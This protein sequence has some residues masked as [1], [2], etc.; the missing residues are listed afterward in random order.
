MNTLL[1][2]SYS[3]NSPAGYIHIITEADFIVSIF[4]TN[5]SNPVN[6]SIENKLLIESVNQ[7]KAYFSGRLHVFDLPL[8][9]KGT[10]FQKEVWDILKT[11]PFGETRTYS[12]IAELAGGPQYTRAVGNANGNNPIA[13]IIPCHR[14]IGA[15]GS[16][17]GYAGGIKRKKWLLD[18]ERQHRFGILELFG[19]EI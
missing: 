19:P 7:L 6:Y 3:F 17:V 2:Q 4:F 14:V 15:N 18:H 1:Q 9:P 8:N 5:N 16:L 10:A 12:T 11:I 13:I